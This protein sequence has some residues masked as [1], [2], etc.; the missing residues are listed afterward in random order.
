MSELET[1]KRKVKDAQKKPKDADHAQDVQNAQGDA[2]DAKEQESQAPEESV[3]TVQNI[4]VPSPAP[5]CPDCHN[6]F[7]YD[8]VQI[9]QSAIC[10]N[11]RHIVIP[12]GS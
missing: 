8:T 6:D 7:W 4:I 9:G 10:P 1:T 12:V 3:L 11:C 5:M 2:R